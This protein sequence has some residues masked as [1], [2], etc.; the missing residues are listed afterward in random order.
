MAVLKPIKSR[1]HKFKIFGADIEGDG[2]RGIIKIAL[3][4]DD[5]CEVFD[6]AN[7]FVKL[8]HSHQFRDARIY[9]HNLTYD[10]GCLIDYLQCD[11]KIFDNSGEIFKVVLYPSPGKPVY[12]LDSSNFYPGMSVKQLGDIIG[13][14]KY[15][16]PPQLLD[17]EE[18][19]YVEEWYCKEHNKLWCVDCY[20]LRDAEIVFRAMQMF[21]EVI[22]NLGG[23]VGFTLASTAMKV[24]K[25]VFLKEQFL[26]PSEW[27]NEYC[28]K[29][30]YAGRVENFV[31]GWWDSVNVYD[32]ISAYPWAMANVALPNPNYMKFTVDES[33]K[34]VIFDYDGIAEVEIEVPPSEPLILPYKYKDFTVYA[35]GLL[36]GRWTHMELREAIRR[37]AKL[38]RFYS[39]L[40]TT[41]N[42]YALREYAE[43]LF[44]LRQKYKAEKSP[45]ELV[46]KIL[47]NSLYGKFGQRVE[48]NT[49]IWKELTEDDED[50]TNYE[51]IEAIGEREF[52]AKKFATEQPNYVNL[53]WATHITAAV[54]LKL[55]EY[56]EQLWDDVFY[57]DT[58]SIHTTKKLT[59]GKQ[60]GEL[61]EEKTNQRALYVGPKEYLLIDNITDG[62][63]CR[64]KGINREAAYLYLVEGRAKYKKPTKFR[65]SLRRNI[66]PSVWIEIVKERK[67]SVTK[68]KF[69]PPEFDINRSQKSSAW[70]INEF[71]AFVE[72]IPPDLL[73]MPVL[74]F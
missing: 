12:L 4:G 25:S 62:I 34:N 71:I 39:S 16:T 37:G 32:I 33:Q 60:L 1:P 27:K 73:Y 48:G 46:I 55:F 57:C 50:L 68:R 51:R 17:T 45:F 2:Q 43:T 53:L 64:A 5:V 69:I 14:Q 61:K 35:Y 21:Y 13:L 40:Y 67:I 44:A 65:E 47:L 23:E 26:T 7:K 41:Q 24:F 36:K 56:I 31:R 11:Y 9:F 30:Y 52:G 59:T 10:F 74:S 28:R 19:L 38:R 20:C 63:T 54:R 29:G 58:D 66:H 6:D 22:E 8:L 70:E 3:V 49:Y 72:K 18:K 15:P 42:T